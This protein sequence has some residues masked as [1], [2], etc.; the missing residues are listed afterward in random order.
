MKTSVI[1]SANAS[2]HNFDDP[3]VYQPSGYDLRFQQQGRV[4][5]VAGFGACYISD[6]GKR[7]LEEYRSINA[8]VAMPSTYDYG[9]FY[10]Y[11]LREGHVYL[12]KQWHWKHW[13]LFKVDG[14][15]LSPMN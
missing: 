6:L 1:A 3:G 5:T 8:D 4:V 7:S 15:T 13:V 9:P 10:A 14:I 12:L 11:P 2:T